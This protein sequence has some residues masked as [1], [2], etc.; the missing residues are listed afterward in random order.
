MG[1][2]EKA[3]GPKQEATVVRDPNPFLIYFES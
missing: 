1:R 3:A 2:I